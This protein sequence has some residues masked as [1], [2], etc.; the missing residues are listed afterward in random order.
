MSFANV[1]VEPG[2]LAAWLMIGLALGWLVSK[3]IGDASYGMKGDLILGAIGSL[4]GGFTYGL[5]TDSAGYWGANLGA[6]IGACILIACARTLAVE[7][8]P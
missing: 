6:I 4:A 3:G 2:S 5:F 8:G 7:R 1:T